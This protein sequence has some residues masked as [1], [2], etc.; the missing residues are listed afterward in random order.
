MEKCHWICEAIK[1]LKLKNFLA[2]ELTMNIRKK[3]E[4]LNEWIMYSSCV[5]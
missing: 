3:K 4:N 1:C 5:T 2:S